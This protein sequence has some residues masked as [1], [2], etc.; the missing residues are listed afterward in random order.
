M[1]T[2][3]ATRYRREDVKTE[4]ERKTRGWV[5]ERGPND[6][7]LTSVKQLVDS[8][9]YLD[10]HAVSHGLR[11]LCVSLDDMVDFSRI[12]VTVIKGEPGPR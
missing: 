4:W 1:L 8:V 6:F 12:A 7:Q 5:V 3:K 11:E 2:L 10:G 9:L